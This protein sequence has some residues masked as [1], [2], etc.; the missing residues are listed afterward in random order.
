[1]ETGSVCNVLVID[2]DLNVCKM[3]TK[4]I[5]DLGHNALCRHTIQQGMEALD[6]ASFDV[7]LLDVNLPDGNSLDRLPKIQQLYYHPDIIIITGYGNCDGAEIALRNGAWDYIQKN[8]SFEKVTLSLKR[9]LQYRNTQPVMNASDQQIN[10]KG[11]IGDSA[12][13][14][15]CYR[16]LAKAA[17]NMAHVLITGET[18]TGKELFTRAIHANSPCCDGNLVVVDCAAL[19]ETLVESLLFGHE[20]GAFTGADRSRQGL[21]SQADNGTL[22]LDEVGEMPI[23]IQKKFL[24]VL[25]ERQYRPVGGRRERTSNFRLIA[26]TNQ[27][28]D[29]LVS[30]GKFRKDLLY[31]LRASHIVLPALRNRKG[32][33]EQLTAHHVK[34]I[35]N[36]LNIQ[37]KRLSSDFFETLEQYNWPGNVRELV[38]MLESVVSENM[39]GPML[40]ATH[41]P[42]RVRLHAISS[43]L[44]TESADQ[45]PESPPGVIPDPSFQVPSIP[46]QHL[47]PLKEYRK[48]AVASAEKTYLNTLLSSLQN[49][50]N[51]AMDVSGL[52]RSR[53]YEL[54]KR[55]QLSV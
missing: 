10:M 18:G 15:S 52:S 6:A 44:P 25:Q 21:I 2:D 12:A 28:L 47:P 46:D 1:M 36:R 7:V 38:N 51:Q 50:I 30:D 37:P 40:V 9:A 35:C 27:D 24:R 29:Q 11:I 26:A 13:M 16:I 20:K 42:H 33:V 49:N 8:D 3:L 32:D 31:R 23:T 4:I 53:F 48:V 34:K 45:N 43:N 5:S 55:H 19:P 14:K 41:L 39:S 17:G 54:V 22:F